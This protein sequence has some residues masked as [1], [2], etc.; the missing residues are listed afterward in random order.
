MQE[1]VNAIKTC[2]YQM[3]KLRQVRVGG[4]EDAKAAK[5]P[6]SETEFESEN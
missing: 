2:S 3:T 5:G 1:G 4:A 6:T